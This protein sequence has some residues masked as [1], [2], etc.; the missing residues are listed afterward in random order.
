M[1]SITDGFY[2]GAWVDG[3]FAPG[4]ALIGATRSKPVNPMKFYY[5]V[6]QVSGLVMAN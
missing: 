6:C 1:G 3:R 4:L 5:G 2:R